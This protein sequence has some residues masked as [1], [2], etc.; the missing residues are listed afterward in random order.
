M[1]KH[2][3]FSSLVFLAL[4]FS[5]CKKD[6][7]QGGADN[8]NPTTNQKPVV[9]FTGPVSPLE[10]DPIVGGVDT[11][12]TVSASDPDGSIVKVKF[13][14]GTSKIYEDVTAPYETNTFNAGIG[15][16]TCYADAFDNSGD[17]TR[18]SLILTVNSINK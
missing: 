11:K 1:K 8:P 14:S 5:A 13:Y 12:L 10:A 18:A 6:K 7:T 16:V 17:S 4:S 2:L 3:F 9:T 15:T